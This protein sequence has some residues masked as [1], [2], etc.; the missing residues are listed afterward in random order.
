M[1]IHRQDLAQYL[2]EYLRVNDVGDYCPN[3]LQVQGADNIKTLVTGVTAS[4]D[5][6]DA[7][8][9]VKADA[10]LVHHGYFWK[11]EAAEIVGVKHRRIRKLMARNI[12]LF[13]Y[14]LPLDLHP[15]VGN[16]V[17]IAKQCGWSISGSFDTGTPE[18]LG[19]LGGISPIPL[20]DFVD[21]LSGQ[22]DQSIKAIQGHDQPIQS[23]AWCTGAAQ[24]FIE[25]AARVGADTYLSGEVSERTYHLAK[26][27]GVNYIVAGHHAT[28]RYGI[29]ALGEHLQEAISG[30]NVQFIDIPNPF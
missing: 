26:E 18:P 4:E 25:H 10:I 19:L 9:A 21:Q 16:N 30:L 5:L 1:A 11:G 29:K 20:G 13:A 7:A 3:G 6:I 12:N 2:A 27:L 14:H 23:L 15:E 28:E 24:D 17:Q 8:I 22:I